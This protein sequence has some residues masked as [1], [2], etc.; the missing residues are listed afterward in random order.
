MKKVKPFKQ[1]CNNKKVKPFGLTDK[2]LKH[3]K[4]KVVNK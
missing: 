3:K 2:Q 1:S 4:P